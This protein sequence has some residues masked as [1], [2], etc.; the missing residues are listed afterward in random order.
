VTIRVHIQDEVCYRGSCWLPGSCA[1]Q[2]VRQS[3]HI[4]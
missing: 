4:P 3:R 1:A 2:G